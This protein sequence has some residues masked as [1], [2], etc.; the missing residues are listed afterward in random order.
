VGRG[1]LRSADAARELEL[2]ALDD[3][4]SKALRAGLEDARLEAG[5]PRAAPAPGI[6]AAS[7]AGR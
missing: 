4:E 2:A 6:A 5:A 7:V 3:E 1:E